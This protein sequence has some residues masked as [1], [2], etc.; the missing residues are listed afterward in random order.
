M[1]VA[2]RACVPLGYVVWSTR[3]ARPRRGLRLPGP[4]ARSASCCGTPP[5]CWSAA[6]AL[7]AVAR[8]R[9]RLGGRADRPA[10][11]R[12][13]ARRAVRAAR[14]PGVR[15]RLR[16]GLDD[17]RRAVL[18]RCGAGRDAVLLPARLP[19]RRSPRCAASTRRS[20]RSRPRSGSGR[21]ARL[22]PRASLP[23]RQ[24]G[25]ARRRAAGRPAPAGRVRRPA[26]AQLP[27]PDHRDPPAVPHRLQRPGRH[28]AGRRARRCSAWLCSA[29][30]CWPAGI[31]GA[32]GS[33]AGA[34][35]PSSGAGSAGAGRSVVAGL[36][37]RRRCWPSACRC[38]AWS[39]GWSGAPR[40]TLDRRRAAPAR[41]RPRIGLAVAGGLLTTAAALPV[42]WLAVRHRG[43]VTTLVERSDLHRQRDARHR[44]RA[45]PGHRLHPGSCP[46]LYQ[47][48][49]LLLVGYAILFLPRA[50]VERAR[51][52]SSWCRP[53][54]RTSPRSL[55]CTGPGPLRRVTLPLVAARPRRRRRAGR[56]RGLHRADRD[57]A[58]RADR[59]RHAGHRVLVATPPRSPTAPPRPTRWR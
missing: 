20:R 36:V 46:A 37:A 39:A 49:P 18:R 58:A 41:R 10:A 19:A 48:V 38:R 30:S 35:R 23:G 45:R 27:D 54:S 47:T 31:A 51:A 22:P 8:R 2:A 28:P 1:L 9:R 52:R 16:L 50:L 17:P 57:A 42:V 53:C 40:P 24:P 14:R 56:A 55:G 6:V 44:G 11:A 33:A 21:R 3:A 7:S 4:P 43:R 29:S 32:P 13:L 12:A 5:G 26:A 34:A 25:R 15:E 59:R